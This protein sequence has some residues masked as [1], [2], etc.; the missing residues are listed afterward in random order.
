M[1]QDVPHTPDQ[2]AVALTHSIPLSQ[3]E[4]NT[5]EEALVAIADTARERELTR[6][7]EAPICDGRLAVTPHCDI[8]MSSAVLT[9]P[10]LL[11]NTAC[12][13]VES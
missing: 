2:S 10:T 8:I 1:C 6:G 5:K 12:D 7:I 13:W 3:E 11:E 4:H 9:G